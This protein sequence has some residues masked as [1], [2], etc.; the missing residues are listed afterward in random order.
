VL[1][2]VVRPGCLA[3]TF[4]TLEHTNL[5]AR[6]ICRRDYPED[7]PTDMMAPVIQSYRLSSLGMM[8]VTARGAPQ[9]K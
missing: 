6:L 9:P 7:P 3:V 4:D 8:F 5:I 1:A 2:E